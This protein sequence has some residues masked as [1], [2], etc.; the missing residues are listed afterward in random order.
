MRSLLHHY[1]L[2][3]KNINIMA[4][5]ARIRENNGPN[6]LFYSLM[7]ESEPIATI[8]ANG[9]VSAR[10]Q[11]VSVPFNGSKESALNMVNKDLP[12]KVQ[13]EVVPPYTQTNSSGRTYT[14][15]KKWYFVPAGHVLSE[16][17]K[18]TAVVTSELVS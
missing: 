1:I 16:I 9:N 11:E 18:K 4:N 5:V 13:F 15:T 14:S 2:L 3:I 12:G 17:T 6:G 10:V 7:V 8:S